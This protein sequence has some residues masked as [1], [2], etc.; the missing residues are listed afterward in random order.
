M[1][2]INYSLLVEEF[3]KNQSLFVQSLNEYIPVLNEWF[4]SLKKSVFGHYSFNSPCSTLNSSYGN[5]YCHNLLQTTHLQTFRLQKTVLMNLWVIWYSGKIKKTVDSTL[6]SRHDVSRR[7]ACWRND[8]AHSVGTKGHK[9]SSSERS[10]DRLWKMSDC[11]LVLLD[12][13]SHPLCPPRM[14]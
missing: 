1:R 6:T 11:L 2:T 8:A 12:T 3:V 4:T 9:S 10:L 7:D 13:S 14:E 5:K